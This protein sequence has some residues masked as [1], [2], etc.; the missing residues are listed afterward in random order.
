[1]HID[2]FL[3]GLGLFKIPDGQLKLLDQ[4]P[5]KTRQAR[6]SAAHTVWRPQA[7]P[8]HCPV[9][10]RS[11]ALK[12]VEDPRQ[13]HGVNLCISRMGRRLP[14]SIS[15]NPFRAARTGCN[16]RSS[17]DSGFGSSA[18]GAT[19]AADLHRRK[20]WPDLRDRPGLPAPSEHDA[21]RD[22]VAARNICHL[23]AR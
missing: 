18:L 9:V 21:G 20:T 13:R 11:S 7:T 15:I 22:T 8:A 2:S 3:F 6:E 19:A 17:L 14:R 23:G 5:V 4:Q 16:R 1:M 12:D 10:W